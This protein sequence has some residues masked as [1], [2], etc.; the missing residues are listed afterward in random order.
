MTELQS[1]LFGNPH[2]LPPPKP[3]VEDV[4]NYGRRS[5]NYGKTTAAVLEESKKHSRFTVAEL[6]A[7]SGIDRGT[8]NRALLRLEAAGKVRKDVKQIAGNGRKA[9]IWVPVIPCP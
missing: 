7:R 6:A 4:G 1:L 5:R 2:P 3:P 8:V 9:A